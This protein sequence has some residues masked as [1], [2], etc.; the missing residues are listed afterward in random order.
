M[1][2]ITS[3]ANPVVVLDKNGERLRRLGLSSACARAVAAVR[4]PPRLPLAISNAPTPRTTRCRHSPT[5]KQGGEGLPRPRTA[6]IIQM[7]QPEA[8]VAGGDSKSLN[9]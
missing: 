9:A 8:P 3:R 1:D 7:L 5:P 4:E 6:R 2:T